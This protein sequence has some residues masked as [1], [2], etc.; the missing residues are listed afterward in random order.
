[1]MCRDS[2]SCSLAG[3]TL[4]KVPLLLVF[5]FVFSSESDGICAKITYQEKCWWAFVLR[6]LVYQLLRSASSKFK[7]LPP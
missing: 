5:R 4:E 3:T 7:K 6:R 1:M 2:A